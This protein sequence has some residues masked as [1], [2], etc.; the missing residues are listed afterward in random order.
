MPSKINSNNDRR[1]FARRNQLTI[2]IVKNW[3]IHGYGTR[4]GN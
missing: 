4:N 1:N 2:Y 3:N